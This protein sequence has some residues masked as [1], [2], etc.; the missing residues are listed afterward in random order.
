MPATPLNEKQ[1]DTIAAKE[2]IDPDLVRSISTAAVNHGISPTTLLAVAKRETDFGRGA[3]F[4]ATTGRGDF[5]H[6]YGLFQLDDRTREHG[7]SLSLVQHDPA[8]AADVAASMLA[9]SL[10]AGHDMH[11]ALHIYN[12]GGLG[13]HTTR[14]SF[15]GRNVDY[16]T[17]VLDWSHQYEVAVGLPSPVRAEQQPTI[18]AA[19]QYL[20]NSRIAEAAE[21]MRGM[22]TRDAQTHHRELE[23]GNVA[24]AYSVNKILDTALGRTYGDNKEYVP[25]LMADLRRHG[26][27]IKANEVEP[28]DI[29]IKLPGHGER[30]G[31]IGVVTRGGESPRI[32]NNSSSRGSLTN[33]DSPEKFSRNYVTKRQDDTVVYLRID[34]ASVD[35]KHVRATPIPKQV[36]GPENAPPNPTSWSEHRPFPIGNPPHRPEHAHVN[37]DHTGNKPIKVDRA[38]DPL[39]NQ[40][41]WTPEMDISQFRKLIDAIRGGEEHKAPTKPMPDTERG[42][43][44]DRNNILDR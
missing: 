3:G 27:E 38:K 10:S 33:E 25:S 14:G 19:D 28:G 43:A 7:P 26:H 39:D 5:G 21:K 40:L 15:E 31:H 1:I 35:L 8:K 34:P 42:K 23:N 11:D 18:H 30:H 2:R 9:Q 32:L 24:C 22:S 36:L 12:H 20:V 16:E 13:G 44:P 37:F 4:D 17:A 29:A 6:G 41:Q